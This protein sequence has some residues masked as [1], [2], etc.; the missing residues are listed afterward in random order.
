MLLLM[1]FYQAIHVGAFFCKAM[2]FMD[3][4]VGRQM[5]DRDSCAAEVFAIPDAKK[6][7]IPCEIVDMRL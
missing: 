6:E 3:I 4:V 7:A 5:T 2:L 1:W